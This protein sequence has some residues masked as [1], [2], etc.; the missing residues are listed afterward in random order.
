MNNLRCESTEDYFKKRIELIELLETGVLDKEGFIN[1]NYALMSSFNPGGVKVT[2]VEDGIIKYHYFNTMA[3]KK[4][5]ESDAIEFKDAYRS[6]RLRDEA[7]DL[8]IKKDKITLNMLETVNYKG[9]E[10]YF[11][12]MN[13]R[14]LMGQIFEIR[15][16]QYEKVVLHSKDRKILYKLK[17]MGCFSE[18]PIASVIATYVNTKIY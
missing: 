8:Y 12:L 7:Y 13:S 2:T 6:R 16:N 18:E 11:I 17:E 3:K 4:M 5:L 1:E 9:V 10:A 15:F 14:S